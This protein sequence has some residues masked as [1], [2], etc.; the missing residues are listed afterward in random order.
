MFITLKKVP[1]GVIKLRN[2]DSEKFLVLARE[3][4]IILAPSQALILERHE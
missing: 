3:I 4:F 2:D 1:R